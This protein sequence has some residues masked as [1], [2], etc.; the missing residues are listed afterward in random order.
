MLSS[1]SCTSACPRHVVRRAE[2]RRSSFVLIGCSALCL[3]ISGMLVTSM[4]FVPAPVTDQRQTTDRV[5]DAQADMSRRDAFMSGSA[6]SA[7][8][9][10]SLF[11]IDDA[12]AFAGGLRPDFVGRYADP[13]AP[14]CKRIL[15]FVGYRA[16]DGSIP[17]TLTGQTGDPD[18]QHIDPAS[19]GSANLTVTQWE[20]PAYLKDMDAK[21]VHIDLSSQGGPAD[22]VGKWDITG[23][24][25]TDGQK[26]IKT[27]GLTALR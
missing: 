11:G 10:G 16:K 6:L 12:D 21:E 25:F 23:I 2:Q 5:D 3:G 1:Q 19:R 24:K 26:W 20:V 17:L 15:N 18:C 22:F 7:M 14:G 8:L 9:A 13:R 27:A 4:A